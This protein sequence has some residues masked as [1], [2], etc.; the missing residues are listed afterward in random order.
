[1]TIDLTNELARLVKFT[2]DVATAIRMYSAYNQSGTDH[3]DA[4]IDLMWLS[5][6]LHNFDI[7]SR[8]ILEGNPSNIVAAC[9]MLLQ[10]FEGYQLENQH[11]T[12]SAKSTFDRNASR[13]SLRDAIA[14]FRDMRAKAQLLNQAA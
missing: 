10:T 6:C 2:A 5:D 8:S 4:S 14:I 13:V 3:K 7:L 11:Q 1:M 9:D 12:R